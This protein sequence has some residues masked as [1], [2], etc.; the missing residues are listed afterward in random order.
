M[1]IVLTCALVVAGGGD[2]VRLQLR[3]GQVAE[4]TIASIDESGNYLF[5]TVG[6]GSRSIPYR[7]VLDIQILRPAE[8]NAW[9]PAGEVE[10]PAFPRSP[11][12]VELVVRRLA[13]L[14]PSRAE[15]ARRALGGAVDL[16]RARS[17]KAAVVPLSE[18]VQREPSWEAARLLRAAVWAE[19]GLLASAQEDA[20]AAVR[21][22][23]EDS[24]AFEVSAEIA[25]RR[26]L[27]RQGDAFYARAIERR[28]RGP[29]REWRLGHFWLDRDPER[30]AAHFEAYR[31]SDPEL[32]EPFAV[33]GKLLR[34]ARRERDAG[35]REGAGQYLEALFRRSPVLAR[36]LGAEFGELLVDRAEALARE[37]KPEAAARDLEEAGF[38]LP[39]RREEL[40]GKRRALEAEAL[41]AASREVNSLEKLT[42]IRARLWELF[43]ELPQAAVEHL[44]RAYGRLCAAELETPDAGGAVACMLQAAEIGVVPSAC[45]AIVTALRGLRNAVSPEA[46]RVLSA[47]LNR[48]DPT[49]LK[50]E[51]S[52]LLDPQLEEVRSTLAGG[53]TA[54][55]KNRLDALEEVFG[56]TPGLSRLRADWESHRALGQDGTAAANA[57]EPAAGGQL[58]TYFPVEMGRWWEYAAG[59]GRRERWRVDAVRQE[60]GV[61]AVTFSGETIGPEGRVPVAREAFFTGDAVYVGA[62]SL[63]AGGRLVLWR[64]RSDRLESRRYRRG[65]RLHEL[66]YKSLNASVTFRDKTFRN[67]RHVTSVSS[68]VDP[69]TG[70]TP[71][72]VETHSWYAPDIG[73]VRIEDD[74]GNHW[75]LVNW[76]RDS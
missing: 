38:L 48:V 2:L 75:E 29:E 21:F 27:S 4:G 49:F 63:E 53:R 57:A 59:D 67:C 8:G 32:A 41:Y 52:F 60:G 13:D 36:H 34:R 46:A 61:T 15:Q 28:S 58:L 7:N 16:V 62:P 68:L 39:A 51:C 17:I 20:A 22:D 37:G 65:A 42:A 76:G 64:P 24:V 10:W 3:D 1:G 18:A 6:G 74:G 35:R 25:Y 45:E 19:L 14:P 31:A 50:Q 12:L 66:S 30:A 44:A 47:G 72:R 5:R 43:P 23:P 26:G 56:P 11:D 40:E 70:P 9:T 69:V 55:V 54:A 33:E 71:F 73:L